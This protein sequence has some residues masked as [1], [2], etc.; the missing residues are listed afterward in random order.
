MEIFNNTTKI[1]KDDL[2][3]EFLLWPPVF[4]LFHDYSPKT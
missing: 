4:D 3:A 2:E 1:V